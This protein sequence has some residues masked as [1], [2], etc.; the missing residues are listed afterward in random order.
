LQKKDMTQRE[1]L[2]HTKQAQE[3]IS[4]II[5]GFEMATG[6]FVGDIRLSPHD[7]IEEQDGFRNI[8]MIGLRTDKFHKV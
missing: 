2:I 5:Y 1:F 3:A 7:T 4:R 6:T 8:V